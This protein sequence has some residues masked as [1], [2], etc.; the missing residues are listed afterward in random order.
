MSKLQAGENTYRLCLRRRAS[1]SSAGEG[2]GGHRK[3]VQALT[4][5]IC[6]S[7]LPVEL[8]MGD[9]ENVFLL[10]ERFH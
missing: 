6:G 7:V 1:E 3:Y 5:N 2:T 8:G 4:S 10:V 9:R